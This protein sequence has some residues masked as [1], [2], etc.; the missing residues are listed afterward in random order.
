MKVV[1]VETVDL[2]HG[3]HLIHVA[4][5]SDHKVLV[6]GEEI[7]DGFTSETGGAASDDYQFCN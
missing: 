4:D 3:V 2:G 7:L 6:G 1:R 5:G